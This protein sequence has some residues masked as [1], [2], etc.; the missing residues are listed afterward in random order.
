VLNIRYSLSRLEPVTIT[1]YDASGRAVDAVSVSP[2]GLSGQ[3]SWK[4]VRAERGIY[5][6][7]FGDQT[8]K[9]VMVK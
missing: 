4:P 1:L 5:F 6:L 8:R 2:K 3:I 9:A 7:K